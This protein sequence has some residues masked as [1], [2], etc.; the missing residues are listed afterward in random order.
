MKTINL[1]IST[2]HAK[3]KDSLCGLVGES[4]I[5]IAYEIVELLLVHLFI[6][7]IYFE[8]GLNESMPRQLEL[9]ESSHKHDQ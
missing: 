5:E 7:W 6:F 2:L 8:T 4:A 9:G 1:I 3:F